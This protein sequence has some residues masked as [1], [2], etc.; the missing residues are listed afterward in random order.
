MRTTKSDLHKGSGDEG[1]RMPGIIPGEG[2]GGL[3]A[4]HALEWGGTGGWVSR[5]GT[6]LVGVGVC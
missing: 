5:R 3:A 4:G 1:D 2:G 6:F